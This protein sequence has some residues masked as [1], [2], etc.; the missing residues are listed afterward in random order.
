MDAA[1]FHCLAPGEAHINQ[2]RKEAA[3]PLKRNVGLNRKV[4]E[5]GFGIRGA[6]VN[7]E[8]EVEAGL[9]SQPDELQDRIIAAF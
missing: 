7:L 8:L 1:I 6:S 5:P 2:T 3:M 9:V 4:G